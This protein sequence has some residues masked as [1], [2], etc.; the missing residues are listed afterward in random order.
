MNT[1]KGGIKKPPTIERHQSF[2]ITRPIV[3]PRARLIIIPFK[4]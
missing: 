3:Q 2:L 4:L 1:N